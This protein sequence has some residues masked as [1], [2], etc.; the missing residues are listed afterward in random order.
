VIEFLVI[1]K[2]SKPVN[3]KIFKLAIEP[4]QKWA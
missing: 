4:L 2:I 3:I 1:K